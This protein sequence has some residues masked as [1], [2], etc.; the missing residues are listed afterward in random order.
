MLN[1]RFGGH[2][3]LEPDMDKSIIARTPFIAQHPDS[4]YAKAMDSIILNLQL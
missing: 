1:L 4:A 2:L 3:P